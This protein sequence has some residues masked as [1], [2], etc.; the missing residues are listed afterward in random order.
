M[1][2]NDALKTLGRFIRLVVNKVR[3]HDFVVLERKS[4]VKFFHSGIILTQ[5]KTKQRN[6]A[7]SGHYRS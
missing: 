7:H 6:K 2:L 3:M 1:K 4:P 5:L